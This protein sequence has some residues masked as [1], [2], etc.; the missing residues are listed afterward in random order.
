M[1]TLPI[2]AFCLGLLGVMLFY[3]GL[4][5]VSA[6]PM[7]A[8]VIAG[9]A[10]LLF[11]DKE[12]PVGTRIAGATSIIFCITPVLIPVVQDLRMQQLATQRAAETRPLFAQLEERLGEIEPMIHEYYERRGYYPE[13]RGSEFLPFVGSDGRLRASEPMRGLDVPND[14]FSPSSR[15]LR[16]AVLRDRGVIIASVGQSGVPEFPMPPVLMDG[17]PA[18][19]WAGFALTGTDPRHQTYDPTNGALSLGDVVHFVG[20]MDYEE[21]MEPLF[22]AWDYVHSRHPWVH[23]ADRPRRSRG[24]TS[25]DQDS[26]S[27]R[28]ARG[29]K[30]LLEQGRYLAALA[31]A[32][33]SARE[34]PRHLAQWTDAETELGLI[35]GL[36]FYHLGCF[37]EGADALL[38][39][40]DLH[41]NDPVGHFYL[42]AALHR[43]MRPDDALVHLAAAAMIAPNHQIT[44]LATQCYEAALARQS[45]P[46]PSPRGL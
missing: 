18:S 15:P 21:A 40:V 7:A 3:G 46:F 20:K 29:A 34:R 6:L 22:D 8:G 32:S 10:A 36:A 43:G 38:E 17:E 11:G 31:L 44:P 30:Q 41:P 19:P 35:R 45:P 25:I 16:W 5:E 12:S 9:I 14:P 37:R 33:R 27:A 2:V 24:D 23:P 13:I 42:G 28:D 1:S 26:Q 39:Y 4:A